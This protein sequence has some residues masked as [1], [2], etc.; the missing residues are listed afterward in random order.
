MIPIISPI[1]FPLN[2]HVFC[3]QAMQLTLPQ[4]KSQVSGW[5][6]DQGRETKFMGCAISMDFDRN[7]FCPGNFVFCPTKNDQIDLYH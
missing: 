4:Q 5:E 6:T 3:S 1:L 7:E 2:H